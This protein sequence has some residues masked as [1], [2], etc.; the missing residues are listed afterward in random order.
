MAWD[1]GGRVH[2]LV[3]GFATWIVWFA[4]AACLVLALIYLV[5][6]CQQRPRR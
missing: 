6:L 4:V 5:Q 2:S 3:Y 1:L